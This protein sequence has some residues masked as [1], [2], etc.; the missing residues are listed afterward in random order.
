MITDAKQEPEHFAR[1]QSQSHWDILLWIGIEAGTNN[2]NIL[3]DLALHASNAQPEESN[4]ARSSSLLEVR[5]GI[6]V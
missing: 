3:P 2:L 1:S 4:H 5:P 6:G